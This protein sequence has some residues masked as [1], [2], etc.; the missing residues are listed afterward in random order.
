[1]G[2]VRRVPDAAVLS[3]PDEA[4][5]RTV[6]IWLG[7]GDV[8][9]LP[10]ADGEEPRVEVHEVFGPPLAV[11]CADGVLRVEHREPGETLWAALRRAAS[12][13]S[14]PTA[15]MA[16]VVPVGAAVTVRVATASV[17][18]EGGQGPL[19]VTTVTGPVTLH[20]LSGP[21]TVTAGAAA[22]RATR[23]TDGLTV[24]TGTGAVD[25]QDSTL[26]SA[27][28]ATMSGRL[29]LELTDPNCLVTSNTAGGALEIRVPPESGYDVT[30][31]APEGAVRI[32]DETVRTQT[33]AGVVQRVE[34]AD[35]QDVLPGEA[36]PGL[37]PEQDRTSRALHRHDGDRALVV[38]ARTLSGTVSLRRDLE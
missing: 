25:I 5:V 6:S 32:D 20:R 13:L 21:V 36:E 2:E 1:M 22:V 10:A 29:D 9:I 30:V 14:M 35:P 7:G 3:W 24:K 12:T 16:V 19:T 23:L 4:P 17:Y 37:G 27:R 33:D 26:R 31:S 38:K 8:A 18:V 34:D 15:R 11:S 28:L